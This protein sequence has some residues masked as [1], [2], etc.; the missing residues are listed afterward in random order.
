MHD[1]ARGNE[2]VLAARPRALLHTGKRDTITRVAIQG[3]KCAD[4][5]ELFETDRSQQFGSI[6]KLATRKLGMLDAAATLNDL[7][8]PPG[9]RLEALTRD[10][11]GQ[12]SIRINDQWRICFVWTEA[13]PTDVEITK[14]Y[15]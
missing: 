9:N 2:S 12:H 8:S 4:T 15:Q 11:A 13:G 1:Y 3:F 5:H 7:E 6:R 14:H 10:R